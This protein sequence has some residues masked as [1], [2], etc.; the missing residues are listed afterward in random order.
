[1]PMTLMA[2]C[3]FLSQPGAFSVRVGAMNP[4][5]AAMRV[6]MVTACLAAIG[7]SPTT[8]RAAPP[9]APAAPRLSPVDARHF[10]DLFVWT[11]TCNVYVLRDGES[12]IL[13]DLGD[14]S[15]LDHLAEIGV[16]KV[17]WVL[18]THH[19]REQ[20]QGAARLRGTGTQIAGPEAERALFERPASFRKMKPR[21]GDQYS[22]H[23]SSYVRPPVTAIKLD[24]GLSKMDTFTWRGREI[25]AVETAGNS[26][27]SL[28]YTWASGD[29][30]VAITGD[31]M[32][33][34]ARMH[35]FFDSE[36]DYSFAAG[37]YSLHNA[38]AL[39]EDLDPALMLPSHGPVIHNP[40]PQLHAYQGKLRHLAQM[41][42]RGYDVNTYSSAEQDRVSK[43]TTV[44]FLWRVLPHL[45]KFKGPN[46]YPNFA[47]VL[48]DSGHGLLVDA[49]LLDNKFLDRTI[50]LARERLGLKFIDA[51]LVSH[52]HGDHFLN[53]PHLRDKWGTK[54]W[55]LDRMVDK[56]Q[57]PERFDYA[58]SVQSYNAGF[59]S[60]RV[61]RVLKSGEVI[62]WEG[63]RFAADWMP[64]QTEFAMCLWGMIDGRKVAFTGDH[65][66]G[67]ARD[68]KHSG[69]E[70]IVA[71]N[72]GIL[73]EGYILGAEYLA[74]L[75][76]DILIGGH[77]Y[78][79]DRPA[80]L[81]DRY[82]RWA[83]GMRTAFQA[84][85]PEPDY[86]TWFDP[87]WVRAEP[88]RVT[89]A[90]NAGATAE[91]QIHVR[92]FGTREQ[93]HR[94]AIHTPAGIVA[95]PAVLEGTLP[96]GARRPFAVRLRATEAA[97]AG[98]SIV[99]MDVT[100]DGRRYG[101]WFDFMVEVAGVGR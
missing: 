13:F 49:G 55:A 45:Y 28:T 62:D 85:S 16:R 80:G 87:F 8:G 30:R 81:I 53:A 100:L 86:R 34:G 26:P 89:L 37:I 101:E 32:V 67:D 66:F 98:V 42:V 4:S 93:A 79:M 24:R 36:W 35:T 33:D 95:E 88:F 44:P 59:D 65:I 73:E 31:V 17:D 84:L 68:P 48:S 5:P 54:V 25:L 40:K 22:V 97:A 2:M 60:V 27:G 75:K 39:V 71:R 7:L 91:V 41:V 72:S 12:A 94:V 11:D 90:R 14:G 10:P 82:R 64:G 99:A 51:V 18:F 20:S 15:V 19:H 92:N 77:S 58:A 46:F 70:A 76:P 52:M 43:P 3:D 47:L 1:M 38:A 9:P 21:L 61:D 63:F 78:V 56:M 23:G 29:G 74:R 50:E 69:H 6:L 57:A 83:L 96:A